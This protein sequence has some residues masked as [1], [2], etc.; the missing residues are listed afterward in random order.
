MSAATWSEF[1]WP[2]WVPVKLRENIIESHSTPAAWERNALA[3][4]N[5]GA[6]LGTRGMFWAV[7]NTRVVVGRYVHCWN[8]I[9]VVILDDASNETVSGRVD[10]AE[11]AMHLE[12]ISRRIKKLDATRQQLEAEHA[13]LSAI[14]AK[15]GGR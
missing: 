1:V 8:N 11:L 5:R 6:P 13:R 14:A 10:P 7:G 15:A 9:G 2:N 12:S 3:P 4:Y